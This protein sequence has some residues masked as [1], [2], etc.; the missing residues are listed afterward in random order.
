MSCKKEIQGDNDPIL[1]ILKERAETNR[2]ENIKFNLEKMSSNQNIST[3][4]IRL[5]QKDM[6]PDLEQL[7][8]RQGACNGCWCMY[9]RIGAAYNKRERLLNKNDLKN[10]VLAGQPIGLL[11]YW[12]GIPVGWCQLTPRQ[13]LSWLLRN[14]YADVHPSSNVWNISCFYIKTGFRKKGITYALIKACIEHVRN[15]GADLLEVYLRQSPNSFTGY[16]S[17]F[18]RAGTTLSEEVKYKRIVAFFDFKKQ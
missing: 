4:E 10:I 16:P 2:T 1:K 8:G 17:T 14:G 6:W 7:F 12:D 15:K 18:K 13:E 3:L 9:W 11:A 5:L